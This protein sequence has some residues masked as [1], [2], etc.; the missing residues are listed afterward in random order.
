MSISNYAELE[1]LDHI[2][3]IG[4]YSA[5]TVYIALC[6]ADPTDAGTGASMNEVAN[7]NGYA[8][9]AI[10]ADF[11]T[12]AAAGAVSNDGQIDFAAASGGSWGTITHFALLDSGTHGAGNMLWYGALSASKTVEDGD[13]VNFAIGNLTITLD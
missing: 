10:A 7:S 9:V 13:T 8:R 3:G 2:M 11:G 5:P 1:L 4:A 6:T 12:P